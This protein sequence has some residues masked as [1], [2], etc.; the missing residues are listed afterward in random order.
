MFTLHLTRDAL[1]TTTYEC[2]LHHFTR[3]QPTPHPLRALEPEMRRKKSTRRL[4]FIGGERRN[5]RDFLA[6]PSNKR[7][8]LMHPPRADATTR[9]KPTVNEFPIYSV[10]VVTK[11]SHSA[12]NFFVCVCSEIV[13]VASIAWRP[14]FV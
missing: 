12:A 2:K 3:C 1:H 14:L 5:E 11:L 7:K 8:I 4:G 9:L 13:F 10:P 6:F